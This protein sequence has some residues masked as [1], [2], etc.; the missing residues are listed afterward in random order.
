MAAEADR[1]TLDGSP[2]ASEVGLARAFRG[3][4]AAPFDPRWSVAGRFTPYGA[5]RTLRS[6][7]PWARA[8][9]RARW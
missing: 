5:D 9:A 7:T 3:I 4:E 6:R 8:G 2:F 1:L